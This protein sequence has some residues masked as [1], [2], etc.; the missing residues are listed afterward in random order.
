MVFGGISY[1]KSFEVT[2]LDQN[3]FGTTLDRIDPGQNIGIRGGLGYAI[4]YKLTINLSLNYSYSYGNEYIYTSGV[5]KNPDS[6][7]ASFSLGTG[8]RLS[9][10]RSI[11]IGISRGLSNTSS[12]FSISV[13]LPFNF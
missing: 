7:S 10:K 9:P 11:S 12:D 2:N 5:R 3:R 6:A 1:G 8:W 4:S 13:R